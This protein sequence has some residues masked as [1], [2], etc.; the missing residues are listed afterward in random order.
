MWPPQSGS[1][2]LDGVHISEWIRDDLG[3]YIGYV[4]Q[5]IEFF[6]GTVAENIARLGE[7]DSKMVVAVTR[8]V[9]LHQMILSFPKGYETLLGE[10]G[11]P[12][13]GGQKQRLALAR[14]IYGNPR[15]VVM[16]EPNAS[17]DDSGQEALMKTIQNLKENGIPVIFTT[18]RHQLIGIADKVLILADGKLRYFGLVKDFNAQL[19]ASQKPDS[20]PPSPLA[21]N[22][23]S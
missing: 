17:L 21:L 15:F 16:D 23:A 9:R 1:A 3:Q 13:T 22:D 5:D 11:H 4:P 12:L 19:A 7:V 20:L 10:N 14:A 2:R 18:H 8:K 6:E